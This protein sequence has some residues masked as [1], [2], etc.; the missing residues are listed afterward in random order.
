MATLN[1]QLNELQTAR[2]NMKIALTEKG[3]TVTNDIRTYAEAI[4][5][6]SGGGGDTPAGETAG[7]KI[8]ESIEEM[9]NS[10]GNSKGD[11]VI[12]YKTITAN[13]TAE[14]QFQTA[15]MPNTVILPTAMEGSH[16][17]IFVAVDDSQYLECRGMFDSSLFYLHCYSDT[18]EVQVEYTSEDGITYTRTDGGEETVDFG[19]MVTYFDA[20]NWIDET[21]YFFQ[22]GNKEFEGLFE[23]NVGLF[24]YD[25]IYFLPVSDISYASD[26]SASWTGDYKESYIL[27]KEVCNA[28]ATALTTASGTSNSYGVTSFFLYQG[29]PSVVS[30]YSS[31]AKQTHSTTVIYDMETNKYYVNLTSKDTLTADSVVL[32]QYDIETGEVTDTSVTPVEGIRGG[33]V[34]VTELAVDTFSTYIGD[35][36]SGFYILVDVDGTNKYTYYKN[37]DFYSFVRYDAFVLAKTQLTTTASDVATGKIFYGADGISVG[38]A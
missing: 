36:D 38:T 34:M 28:A 26:G 6:I 3:Q 15:I 29:K 24:D 7:A 27:S 30:Y 25:N 33:T 31:L 10:T 8:F 1:E 2:D 32:H 14:S 23:Y 19:M 13:A 4:S 20:D 11:L 35:G 21:G 22:V 37:L 17:P 9:N 16:E 5:G 18:G 12:V